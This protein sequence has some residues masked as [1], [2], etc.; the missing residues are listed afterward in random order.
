VTAESD[1]LL[2]SLDKELFVVTLT[3]HAGASTAARRIIE[4]HLGE[5]N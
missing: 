4:D 5:N 2:Y 3:R 1:T